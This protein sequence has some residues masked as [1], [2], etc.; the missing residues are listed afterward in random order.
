M[1]LLQATRG[2]RTSL[3]KIMHD[4]VAGGPTVHDVRSRLSSVSQKR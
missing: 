4:P 1:L 3:M 2:S